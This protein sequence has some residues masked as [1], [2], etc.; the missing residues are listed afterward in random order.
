MNKKQC[1]YC[2]IS[3][4][5][6]PVVVRDDQG[7]KVLICSACQLGEEIT[8]AQ[9]HLAHLLAKQNSLFYRLRDKLSRN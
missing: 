7:E 3:E 5:V 2:E 8:A 9:E 6:L 1:E 4:T